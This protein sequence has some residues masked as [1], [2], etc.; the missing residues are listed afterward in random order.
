MKKECIIP[1]LSLF[2]SSFVDNWIELI[3]PQCF[4]IKITFNVP[5][6]KYNTTRKW[7]FDLLKYYYTCNFEKRT[8]SY[9]VVGSIKVD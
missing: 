7:L 8:T 3:F 1:G 5:K 6:Q 9:N 2:S 4:K